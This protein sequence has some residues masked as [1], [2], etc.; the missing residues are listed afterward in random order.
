M[1]AAAALPPPSLPSRCRCAQLA[2]GGKQRGGRWR[3][4][5]SPA[6]FFA[7]CFTQVGILRVRNFWNAAFDGFR[8]RRKGFLKNVDGGRK[9]W[10][11]LVVQIIFQKLYFQILVYYK[12]PDPLVYLRPAPS[13]WFIID[14]QDRSFPRRKKSPRGDL[15]SRRRSLTVQP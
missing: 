7:T 11:S 6:S 4:R 14:S 1:K 13:I 2:R 8:A 12:Q 15:L 9:S 10:R 5:G 3:H